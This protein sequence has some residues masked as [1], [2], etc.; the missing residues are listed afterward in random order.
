MRVNDL[1]DLEQVVLEEC[2]DYPGFFLHPDNKLIAAN[3]NGKLIN[4]KTGK[5]I[6]TFLHKSGRFF[7]NISKKINPVEVSLND[8]K[9]LM[10]E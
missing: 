3:K 8:L 6:K 10:G 1:N 7:V 4:V 5:I 9:K 2:N